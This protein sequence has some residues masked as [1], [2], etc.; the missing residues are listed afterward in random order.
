MNFN[1]LQ[2]GTRMWLGVGLLMV[3]LL[4]LIGFANWRSQSVQARA[5]AAA[6]DV[7]TKLRIAVEWAALT[8]N[9][10]T[11]VI[12][13]PKPRVTAAAAGSEAP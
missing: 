9:N 13:I 2:I 6:A 3:A 10:R 4:S 8:E 7:D 12:T 1:N 11:V 5:D